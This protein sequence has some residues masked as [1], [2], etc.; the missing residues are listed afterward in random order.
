MTSD[1]DR[2]E[3]VLQFY[4]D[5]GYDRSVGVGDRPALVVIDFSR[6][7]TG[8]H[9]AFPGG[10]FDAEIGQT[11]RL[12]AGFREAAL[13]ILYTTIAYEDPA[14]DAGL[15]AVKVPWLASCL[16][17]SP[18]VEIDPALG[19]ADHE[20]VVVKRFPSIL[21]GT[22][23]HERLQAHGVDSLVLTGCTTSVC[24]R[25]SAVD[26]MQHGYRTL[27]AAEA[28]G[29]FTPDLH[30]LH[31]RDIGARYADV[32]PVDEVLAHVRRIAASQPVGA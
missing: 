22:G 2:L 21:F 30:A 10:R 32:L 5:R 8:G 25:A 19:R 18:L 28:V 7:F 27:V 1:Q 29:D 4:A 12:I 11:R 3:R 16:L 6:A 13:P 14:R 31:L 15:W 17:G 26:A 20:P 24:V 9:G 23:L